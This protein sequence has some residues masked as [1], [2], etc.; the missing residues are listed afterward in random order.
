MDRETTPTYDPGMYEKLARVED[1]HFWFQARN[2]AIVAA[3]EQ[4][5]PRL[6]PGYR[7]LE[8]GCGTG[9]VL[10]ALQAVVPEGHLFGMDL[11]LQGLR[12]AA[13]RSPASR[14]LVGDA[15]HPPFGLGFDVIGAFDV[16][17]HV[18]DDSNVLSQL[19]QLLKPSGFLILTVPADPR[20]W[21]YFDVAAHHRRRYRFDDLQAKLAA[22]GYR[23]DYMT[24]FMTVLKPVLWAGRHVTA[25]RGRTRSIDAADLVDADLQVRPAIGAGLGL[26]LAPEVRFIRSRRRLPA[27]TS[28]LAVASRA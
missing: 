22:T 12:Y 9:N 20:L 26:M 2:R 3:F 14:L 24:P 7:V 1:R 15:A 23:V 16:I 25:R 8:V 28:L 10:R 21:S 27:G 6:E 4:I 19:G 17:E 5:R 18:D 11:E 13:R